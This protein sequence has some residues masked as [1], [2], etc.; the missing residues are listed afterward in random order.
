MRATAAWD[1]AKRA[2]LVLKE[3]ETCAAA[4]NMMHARWHLSEIVRNLPNAALDIKGYCANEKLRR[5]ADEFCAVEAFRP[6]FTCDAAAAYET[7]DLD[8]L[9][10][11]LKTCPPALL[12]LGMIQIYH[13]HL[14]LAAADTKNA[15]HAYLAAAHCWPDDAAPFHNAAIE[16]AELGRWDEAAAVVARAPASFHDIEVCRSTA[17]IVA[18]RSLAVGAAAVRR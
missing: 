13:G 11:I 8:G 17:R 14:A 2:M 7:K 16:L 15:I 10:E 5:L 6:R 9:A 4:G 3:A 1:M 18:A 12:S